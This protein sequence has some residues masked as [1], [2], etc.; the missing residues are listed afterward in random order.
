M[1][2]DEDDIKLEIEGME[3]EAPQAEA[4]EE[5]S[6]PAGPAAAEKEEETESPLDILKK[7]VRED[8]RRNSASS[9]LLEAVTGGILY[10]PFLRSQLWVIVI[11]IMFTV[12]YV[13]VRYQCQQDMIAIDGKEKELQD[14]KYRALA[15]ESAL[16]ERCRESRIIEALKAGGDST[17]KVSQ[18]KPYV[19]K[20]AREQ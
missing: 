9:S 13:A 14:A 3:E 20:V 17:L 6:A 2:R 10:R 12:G 8:E 1:D 5:E 16:T 4:A 11:I 18:K 19:V 7:N 15:S